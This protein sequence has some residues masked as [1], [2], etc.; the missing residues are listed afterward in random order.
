[1][2]YKNTTTLILTI[3]FIA[4]AVSAQGNVTNVILNQPLPD[5]VAGDEVQTTFSFNYP[6][7]SGI[8]PNQVDDAPLII[9][10]NIT[11][12]DGDYPVWKGDFE[13]S[14]NLSVESNFFADREYD[15]E[16]YENDFTLASPFSHVEITDINAGEFYCT[17]NDLLMLLL[18][19][20]NEVTLNVKSHPALYPGDYNFSIGLFYPEAALPEL[21]FVVNS[22]YDGIFNERKVYFNI[23]TGK[24]VDQI[25]YIDLNDRRPREI[26]LCR[27]CDEYG[28]LRTRWKNMQD[29]EHNLTVIVRDGDIVENETFSVFIDSKVPRILKIEPRRGFSDGIFELHF[30]EDNPQNLTFVYG[31]S[32]L[33]VSEEIDLNSCFEERRRMKC[34]FAVNV[35][36]FDQQEIKYY[37]SL[38]DIAGNKGTSKES[39][40]SIDLMPPEINSFEYTIDRRRV[41]FALNVSEL[42]FDRIN[43]IDYE[44][45][46]PRERVL[47]TR[48]KDGICESSRVFTVGEHN[49]TISVL[50]K[51][52]N[53]VIIENLN[54]TI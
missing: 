47:C 41:T 35:S 13:V 2:K 44:E 53:M 33:M 15:F 38:E 52:G 9:F 8:Y 28:S 32:S 22:P 54:F 49:L 30:T 5:F 48:L 50:D 31:N 10:V 16:C 29:G 39:K 40:V 11:S 43:Y 21:D 23:T 36:L 7:V 6:G 46:R 14:G 37:A 20:E 18:K 12:N 19:S 24:Q 1:M 45:R 27:N 51:A 3:V 25:S 4:V 17:N 42:N 34:L 26:R